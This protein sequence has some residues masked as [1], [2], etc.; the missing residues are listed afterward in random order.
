MNLGLAMYGRS[1]TLVNDSNS[2]I[3]GSDVIGAGL[4]I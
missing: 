2:T 4:G 3:I 1:F